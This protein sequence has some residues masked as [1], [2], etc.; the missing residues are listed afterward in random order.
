MPGPPRTPTAL[1]L[2][3]GNPSKRAINKNEPKPPSGV[4]PIP[5]HF[6]KQEKYWFKRVAQELDGSG[7]ITTLDG[8]ALE[9]LI[10]AY[11]EWRKHRDFLDQEGDTYTVT[12]MTGDV[13][14]KSH[15]RVAMLADAWKR[16]RGMMAEFGM[17]PSA[18]SKINVAGETEEDL[19]DAFLNKKRK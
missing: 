2:V 6:N 14:I 9:L 7:V 11:V 3:K 15:P 17:T 12:S 16:L 13:M 10:G 5:K 19:L 18:R 8:M 4:P 1:R